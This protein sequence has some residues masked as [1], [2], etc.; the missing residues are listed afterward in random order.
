MKDIL[1][2]ENYDGFSI[3]SLMREP[4]FTFEYKRTSDLLMEMR[5]QSIMPITLGKR[6]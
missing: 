5:E 6:N 3:S 4:N 2:Y 1:F